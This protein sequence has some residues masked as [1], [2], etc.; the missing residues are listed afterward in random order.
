[1]T[2][3]HKIKRGLLLGLIFGLMISCSPQTETQTETQTNNNNQAVG[4]LILV[5]NGEDIVRQGLVTKDG[6]DLTFNNV[7][8]TLSNVTAYQ[9]K[10]S[11]NPE[12][13]KEIKPLQTIVLVDSPIT[14]NL[15]EG[16][17][18]AEPISVVTKNAP[19]GHYNAL[20]WNIAPNNNEPS[21]ILEGTA[22]KDNQ[23]IEFAMKLNPDISYTCGEFIG[24]ERKGFLAENSTSELEV[25]FHFDHLFGDAEL[26]DDD[27]MNQDALGFTS[28]AN[29]AEN[30]QLTITQ[31]LLK[32]KLSPEDYEKLEYNL[33]SL[34]HVG[35]GHCES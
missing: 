24:E 22:T 19:T 17:E 10:S 2:Y 20:A 15:A 28:L 23:K 29:L 8:V 26:G 27:T 35:E 7:Y 9:T 21:L 18:D 4:S 1:M 14:V 31:D 30:G 11:F 6:W 33:R 3:Y 25:T 34:G 32:E 13:S 5:V 16:D 12:E